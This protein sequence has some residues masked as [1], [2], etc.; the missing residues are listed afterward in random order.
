MTVLLNANNQLR[1]GWKL[2]AYAITFLIVRVATDT[3]LSFFFF[4]ANL[5]DTQLAL[6]ALNEIALLVPAVLTLLLMARFVDRRPL[7]AFGVGFLPSWRRDLI[8][9]L[10]LAGAMLGLIL[11]GCYAFGYVHIEWTGRQVPVSTVIA[12]S[13]CFTLSA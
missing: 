9:G 4:G 5:P 7:T 11:L 6:I 8:T 13:F 1:S 3:A 10:I 12:A 2:T